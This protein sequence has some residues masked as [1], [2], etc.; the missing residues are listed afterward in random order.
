MQMSLSCV[1]WSAEHLSMA[2]EYVQD[3]PVCFCK[4]YHSWCVM[5]WFKVRQLVFGKHTRA[6]HQCMLVC[7]V[8]V[9]YSRSVGFHRDLM[10][11]RSGRE[12]EGRA[13]LGWVIWQLCVPAESFCGSPF[14]VNLH[15]DSVATILIGMKTRIEIVKFTC[16]NSHLCESY[17]TQ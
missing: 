4:L 11:I 8:L 1:T 17:L 9:P 15:P 12:S 3:W 16:S 5:T 14:A 2:S 10:H 13:S 6:T 7:T